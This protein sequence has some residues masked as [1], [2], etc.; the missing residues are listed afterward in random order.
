MYPAGGSQNNWLMVL[1]GDAGWGRWSMLQINP[2]ELQ[3]LLVN[4][5]DAV[6]VD[7]RFEY[8]RSAYGYILDSYHIPL[9]TADWDQN[10]NFVSEVA[11]IADQ[12]TPLVFVCRS[13]N[14]SCEACGIAKQHGYA[15]VYNLN[16]G[17]VGL[18]NLR[19][20]TNT[21]DVCPILRLSVR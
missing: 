2:Y 8:E 6:I 17:Y 11:R 9:F 18:V 1:N 15:Q 19:G 13:G 4:K 10:P 12:L 20:Q 7:V 21:D 16:E 3:D 5:P 14:R